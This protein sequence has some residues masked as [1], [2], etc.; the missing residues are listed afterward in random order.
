M[1]SGHAARHGPG[2]RHGA[3]GTGRAR[4]GDVAGDRG[5][6]RRAGAPRNITIKAPDGRNSGFR[7]SKLTSI[8]YV[9]VMMT[10]RNDSFFLPYCYS[11]WNLLYLLLESGL[12]S[13]I[14]YFVNFLAHLRYPLKL[15]VSK[16][17]VR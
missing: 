9:I 4:A 7:H 15:K 11:S 14:R 1:R 2:T 16:P 17:L 8:T 13:V 12:V 6:H 10:V 5:T 3:P